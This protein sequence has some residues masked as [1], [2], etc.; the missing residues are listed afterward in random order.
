MLDDCDAVVFA[1][2]PAAQPE[3]AGAAAE[4]AKAVLVET[5]IAGDLAGAE[6][7]AATVAAAGV[8]SQVALV[9]RYAAA[10]RHFLTGDVPRTHPL[11]GSGRL[12]SAALAR[13]SS[14][15]A[16]RAEM[17]VLRSLGPYLID[18]LDAALGRV[19]AVR[20]HGDRH[21]WIGLLLE[22]SGGR[23]SEASLLAT[24][25]AGS[26]RADVEVF[27]GGGAADVDCRGAAG[28]EASG[29]MFREFAQAVER[30][31]PHELDVPRGLHLQQ[32]IEKAEADL[33]GA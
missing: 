27:G 23:F 33:L 10:V 14:A 2:P 22:H 11:G 3:L 17:G 8:V 24:D 5:P 26:E 31:V 4:R 28:Q 20:A 25:A 12:V 29:T 32:V 30:G 6:Q 19:G 13:G 18:L 7:L 16:W 15:P 21:G 9:W 1:V